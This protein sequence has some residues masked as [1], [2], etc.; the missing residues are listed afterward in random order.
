MLSLH[1]HRK[2]TFQHDKNQPQ[3]SFNW[4]CEESSLGQ[5][6]WKKNCC[7][8][9]TDIYRQVLSKPVDLYKYASPQVLITYSENYF[10]HSQQKITLGQHRKHWWNLFF[11]AQR[12][13]KVGGSD[14]NGLVATT[15]AFP[16]NSTLFSTSTF[17]NLHFFFVILILG[18]LQ[19]RESEEKQNTRVLRKHDYFQ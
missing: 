12:A 5:H 7:Y 4:F 3:N 10:D 9:K 8:C 18:Y 13:A 16:S 1:A 14:A 15:T 19:N 11:L 17:K 6:S 2:L